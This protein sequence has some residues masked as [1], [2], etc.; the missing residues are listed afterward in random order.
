M[1]TTTDYAE[2]TDEEIRHNNNPALDILTSH[3]RNLR[4]L[5][6]VFPIIFA[7]WPEI[8]PH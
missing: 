6:R 5:W 4:H 7:A 1:N 8:E 3:L 2:N